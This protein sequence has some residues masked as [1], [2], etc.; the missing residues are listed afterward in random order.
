MRLKH[1]LVAVACVFAMACVTHAGTVSLNLGASTQDYIQYGF[2]AFGPDNQG[3]YSTSQGTCVE[4]STNTVCTLSGSFGGGPSGFTSGTYSF[5]TEYA[6]PNTPY[7]GP[8]AP[9]LVSESPSPSNLTQYN[10]LAPSTSI[11]LTLY[12]GGKTYLVPMVTGG[13]FD[14][15]T[16]FFFADT[17]YVCTGTAVPV[18]DP[19]EV[20]ITSGA[21]GTSPVTIQVSFTTPAPTSS[22]PEPSSLLLLGT[23]LLGLGLFIHRHM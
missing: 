4:V 7:G 10:F 19:Y 14:A 18:C 17:D 21:I 13:S 1:G 16:S 5:V 15:G 9:G 22:T 23:G 12:T 11:V 3:T 6:G 20:G 8:N 2:G